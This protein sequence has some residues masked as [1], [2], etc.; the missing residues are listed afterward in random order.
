MVILGGWVFLMS[1]VPLYSRFL[2]RT[3]PRWPGSTPTV[4][5]Y[6]GRVEDRG[7]KKED[8]VDSGLVG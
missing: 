7:N 4:V 5:L 3:V 1:E 6:I 2:T 8:G